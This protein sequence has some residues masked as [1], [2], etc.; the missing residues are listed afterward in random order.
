MQEVV[1]PRFRAGK[2]SHRRLP[3]L[4]YI[5]RGDVPVWR[6][7]LIL[8]LQRSA[9]KCMMSKQLRAGTDPSGSLWEAQYIYY[10]WEQEQDKKLQNKP[11]IHVWKT[12]DLTATS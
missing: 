12:S 7:C 6:N 3:E 9:A 8:S 1:S 10:C 11:E 2:L 5:I 4:S